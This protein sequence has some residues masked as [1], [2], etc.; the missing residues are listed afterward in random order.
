MTTEKPAHREL[1]WDL[2]LS[3]RT[4]TNPPAQ[5]AHA[6]TL[7]GCASSAMTAQAPAGSG[8]ILSIYWRSTVEF[9]SAKVYILKLFCYFG[10]KGKLQ[11]SCLCHHQLIAKLPC[12][13]ISEFYR[14]LLL[15]L[16][17]TKS[18]EGSEMLTTNRGVGT[19][20]NGGPGC[21][22]ESRGKRILV[23]FPV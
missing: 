12:T 20:R 21:Q 19:S 10:E 15:P 4:G 18:P 3:A 11:E 8:M 2:L 23:P 9:Y 17:R 13:T 14:Q 22:Q 7:T 5:L 1:S 6:A 16:Q